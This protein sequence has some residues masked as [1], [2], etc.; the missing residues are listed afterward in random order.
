MIKIKKKTNS[1]TKGISV[2]L[3]WILGF[4]LT[5]SDIK[6][7]HFTIGVSVGPLETHLGLSRW[8]SLLP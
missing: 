3:L 4:T 1:N 7:D 2:V 8:A 5:Y 6:G